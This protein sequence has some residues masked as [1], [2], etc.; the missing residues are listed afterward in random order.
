VLETARLPERCAAEATSRKGESGLICDPRLVRLEEPHVRPL[1]ELV[2]RL[3]ATGRQVPNF[4]PNDGG[5]NARALFLLETPGPKAV[6]TDFVSRDN[7]DPSAKNMGAALDQADLRRSDVV[8]WNVVPYCVS[9][10]DKNQQATAAQVRASAADTQAVIDRLPRLRVVVF[11]G[12]KAQLAIP[13]LRLKPGVEWRF[14]YHTGAQ[15]YNHHRE[16][17]HDTFREV[18]RLLNA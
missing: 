8:L 10:A 15:A 9:T 14:T 18:A 4:D 2:N 3:R 16:E 7:P 11:C 6:A 12:R 17:I 13:Y 5:V 1:M